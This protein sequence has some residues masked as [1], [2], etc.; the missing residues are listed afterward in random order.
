MDLD[1]PIATA[2]RVARL[3]ERA[4]IAYGLYGGLAV[5]AYGV[6]RETKDADVAV[7]A[8][9]LV[10]LVELLT[11]DGLH[12]LP[13]FDRVRFGGLTVSRATLLGGESDTGLNT[14]DLVEPASTRYASLAV[15]RAVRAP[16]RDSEICLLAPEDVVIFKLLSTREKDLEDGSAIIRQLGAA[17][18]VAMIDA[19]VE[20]LVNE[21]PQHDVNQRWNRCRGSA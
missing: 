20:R 17:L 21:V 13:T 11:R 10:R 19:E 5:A 8:A 12:A 14:V 7:V 16:L 18:D 3:L 2:L 15:G 9:D 4:E 6:A 1:D